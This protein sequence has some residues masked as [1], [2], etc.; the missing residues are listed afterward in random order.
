[1]KMHHNVL[2]SP[3]FHPDKLG[4]QYLPD[5]SFEKYLIVRDNHSISAEPVAASKTTHT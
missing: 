2:L 5:D 1:M 4:T 3:W